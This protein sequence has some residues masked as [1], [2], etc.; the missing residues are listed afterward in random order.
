LG[1]LYFTKAALLVAITLASAFAIGGYNTPFAAA[2]SDVDDPLV[3]P[4]TDSAIPTDNTPPSVRILNPSACSDPLA[5]P[6][7]FTVTGVAS[8]PESGIKKVEAFSHAM[9]FDGN[10]PFRMAS[11]T[12]GGDWSTWSIQVQI[13]DNATRILVRA[14][15]SSGNE[16]WDEVTVDLAHN[17]ELL[18]VSTYDPANSVAFIDPAFTYAAYGVGGFY[19]FFA[20]YHD[21][22]LDDLIMTDLDLMVAEISAYPDRSY[23]MS[24]VE[25]VKQSTPPDWKLALLSDMDLHEGVIFGP[26]GENVFRTLFLLHN[27]YVTQQEYDNLKRFVYNGGTLVL[28]D[29]NTFYAEVTY[30]KANCDVTLVK[31]HDWEFNG[32]IARPSVSERYQEDN[33]EWVGTNYMINALWDPVVFTN[34]PF[35]YTH[36]EE[37][38]IA[39]SNLTILHDYGLQIAGE[40]DGPDWHRDAT[41]AAYEKSYGDGKV[42]GLGVYG[43]RLSGDPQFLDFFDNVVLSR[44]LGGVHPISSGN[45][46][47]PVY[48]KMDHG[49]VSSITADVEARKLVIDIEGNLDGGSLRLALP[50]DLID[51]TGAAVTTDGFQTVEDNQEGQI[52]APSSEASVPGT[53]VVLTTSNDGKTEQMTEDVIIQEI[54]YERIIEVPLWAGTDKVE[55]Y[56][57]HV[58]PEFIS[59]LPAFVVALV[60]TS[61]VVMARLAAKRQPF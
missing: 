56:G 35:N 26:D 30:D 61:I 41:I 33:A 12:P 45:I 34:L 59:I 55:I 13:H 21:A 1:R 16:N 53:F 32:D 18:R 48:W 47:H 17:K 11:P 40:Y 31:G 36:F 42:I 43:Q 3:E 58:T 38:Y 46:I 50:R 8:D 4:S 15:D 25:R 28:I 9:P 54:D 51:V 57:T 27:E 24:I 10:Y 29:G 19:E 44:A 22:E 60:I 23:Y 6:G 20:K 37:N 5:S 14:T 39:N 49:Q 7:I 52:T 2:Q